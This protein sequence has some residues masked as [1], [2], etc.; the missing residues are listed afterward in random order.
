MAMLRSSLTKTTSGQAFLA[1]DQSEFRTI[2]AEKPNFLRSPLKVVGTVEPLHLRVIPDTSGNRLIRINAN[3]LR[4][5]IDP[6]LVGLHPDVQFKADALQI[7][8]DDD[9]IRING[10]LET[11]VHVVQPAAD[12]AETA[13]GRPTEEGED[14]EPEGLSPIEQLRW[15]RQR[16]ALASRARIEAAKAL[17]RGQAVVPVEARKAPAETKAPQADLFQARAA[18]VEAPKAVV[19]RTRPEK[20]AKPVRERRNKQTAQ[21][22]APTLF[23]A[24][25]ALREPE[26]EPY[27]VETAAAIEPKSHTP[28][29]LRALVRRWEDHRNRNA[30]M[31]AGQ[32]AKIAANPEI[33]GE[34]VEAIAQFFGVDPT[35]MLAEIPMQ[36]EAPIVETDDQADDVDV[37][38]VEAVVEDEADTTPRGK[39]LHLITSVD[40]QAGWRLFDAAGIDLDDAVSVIAQASSQIETDGDIIRARS[41]APAPRFDRSVLRWD[42][43]TM[44]AEEEVLSR[45]DLE[46]QFGEVPFLH[47]AKVLRKLA[48]DGF[49]RILPTGIVRIGA[50]PEEPLFYRIATILRLRPQGMRL[51]AL[52]ALLTEEP[53]S[54]IERA[55]TTLV[56]REH[57]ELRDGRYVWRGLAE[58]GDTFIDDV[59]AVETSRGLQRLD[60]SVFQGIVAAPPPIERTPTGAVL[61]AYV[62]RSR[63]SGNRYIGKDQLLHEISA[64][65][66]EGIDKKGLMERLVGL[67]WSTLS[68]YLSNLMTANKVIKNGKRYRLLLAR[69]SMA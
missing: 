62:D 55:A 51:N 40:G 65:G 18:V 43:L 8:I 7:G 29:I 66:T 45:Q 64:A 58:S 41:D 20:A 38:G 23:T 32:I 25:P 19:E 28:R 2:A 3:S 53:E 60:F 52:R 30:A 31:V 12:T 4:V 5:A 17:R 36:A 22:D 50:I 46:K 54:E 44:L 67:K 1:F 14:Q 35:P 48:G 69:P 15:R 59:P 34:A 10:S 47:V 42:I 39:A 26:I 27:F 24:V 21:E 9:V 13:I 57:V 6:E 68:S 11:S 37:A 63:P 61:T 33:E 56:T 16:K 49:L